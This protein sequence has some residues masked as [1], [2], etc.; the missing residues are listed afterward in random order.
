MAVGC[1]QCVLAAVGSR[2]VG[3]CPN[4]KLKQIMENKPVFEQS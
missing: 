2:E 1:G 3:I 4:V